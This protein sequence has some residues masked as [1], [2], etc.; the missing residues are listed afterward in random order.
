MH[1]HTLELGRCGRKILKGPREKQ[2]IAYCNIVGLINI[3]SLL[4]S[5]S[6]RATVAARIMVLL[7]RVYTNAR[8]PETSSKIIMRLRSNQPGGCRS[9]LVSLSI[10]LRFFLFVPGM[11]NSRY[12][13]FH[14]DALLG[15]TRVAARTQPPYRQASFLC[16]DL[17]KNGSTK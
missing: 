8:F 11:L 12:F 2:P 16:C 9:S 17:I 13:F 4:L 5:Y 10:P 7:I 6:K 1:A 15:G 3:I 14:E